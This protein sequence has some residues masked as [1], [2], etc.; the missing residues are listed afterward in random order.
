MLW[1][2]FIYIVFCSRPVASLVLKMSVFVLPNNK[3]H[4]PGLHLR[5]ARDSTITVTCPTSYCALLPLAH[6][7]RCTCSNGMQP[8]T[9]ALR[10][11]SMI[12]VVAMFCC[13]TTDALSPFGVT[14]LFYLPEW[15]LLKIAK[16][17]KANPVIPGKTLLFSCSVVIPGRLVI[18]RLGL[19]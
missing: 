15:S 12:E 10:Q 14:F 16:T 19:V 7:H 18:T 5:W 4:F 2:L 17:Q 6:L 8:N 3:L 1:H 13:F 9:T 11:N